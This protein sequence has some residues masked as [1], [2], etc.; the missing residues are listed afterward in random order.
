MAI[1]LL[2]S[3]V[4]LLLIFLEFFLPGAVLAVMGTLALLTSLGLFFAYYPAFWGILYMLAL[5]LAVFAICKLGMWRIHRSKKTGN[6]CNAQD[7]EGFLA[8]SFDVS[9][10]GKEGIVSTELKPAGYVLIEGKLYQALS[11]TGFIAKGA[12]IKVMGGKGSHL[13]AR[14]LET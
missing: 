13:I 12:P 5:L 3:C 7:Q 8:S 9:L 6:F 2:L 11:E 4:G 1:I 10:I 14:F